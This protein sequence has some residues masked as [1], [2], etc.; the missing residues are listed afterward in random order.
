MS[1]WHFPQWNYGYT[2]M[3]GAPGVNYN[4][5]QHPGGYAAPPL[6]RPAGPSKPAA[7]PTAA[8]VKTEAEPAAVAS[9]VIKAEPVINKE[10][11]AP[12]VTVAAAAKPEEG[13]VVEK[14]ILAIL[15]GRNPVMFCNDQSKLRGLH[16]EWE[17][18]SEAGPPHDKTYQYMLKMGED[19]KATGSGKNKKDAKTKAAEAM[20]LKLDELPKINKRPYHHQGGWGGPG[21][22]G[23]FH[24]GGWN[25]DAGWGGRGGYYQGGRGGYHN[26]GPHWKRKKGETEDQIL[27]QNDVTP[28]VE[29][30]SQ[31]NPIS[32]LYEFTK[33]KRWP[34]PIFDCVSEDVLEERRTEKGF[35]LRKTNFTI[36]CTV[37]QPAGTGED[38][39][40]MGNALTKKQAKTNAASIAWAELGSGVTQKSVENLLTSGRTE[41]G[42]EA[43][44]I[45]V[46][47]EAAAPA[48]ETVVVTPTQPKVVLHKPS[49]KQARYSYNKF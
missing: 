5:Y 22:P 45:P 42:G 18:V 31:N 39:V 27:K 23:G 37:R 19:L 6:P 7:K 46:K 36:R 9:G 29:N 10:A 26:N 3:P 15:R 25:H 48:V 14:S 1:G 28:K 17:Q 24:G 43:T 8:P 33:K 16:M 2:Q 47:S 11:A 38:K 13:E 12:A 4:Y 32:K 21:G 49:D 34:E 41:A 35:T 40:Y 20:V 44:A 30:P